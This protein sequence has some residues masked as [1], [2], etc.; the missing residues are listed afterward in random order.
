MWIIDLKW[1]Y[2][3]VVVCEWSSHCI[4]L[5]YVCVYICMSPGLGAYLLCV[6]LGQWQKG[7]IRIG[8]NSVWL[9]ALRCWGD[10]AIW[11]WK[12][13]CVSAAAA[14]GKWNENSSTSVQK[15]IEKEHPGWVK[16]VKMFRPSQWSHFLPLTFSP[17]CI[18]YLNL[19]WRLRS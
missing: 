7:K 4:T 1:I 10:W 5:V 19:I 8:G 18:M 13:F 2:S 11:H 12:G 17:P 15:H 3:D 16:G 14:K 9:C 6:Y